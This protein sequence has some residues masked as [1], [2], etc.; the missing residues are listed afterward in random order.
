MQA[1]LPRAPPD[2]GDPATIRFEVVGGLSAVR[3]GERISDSAL[4]SRKARQLLLA[5]LAARGRMVGVD[6]IA[7][8]LWPAGAGGA[9]QNIASLVSRLRRDLGAAV[10]EGGRDGY[11]LGAPPLVVVDLDDA[12]RWAREAERRLEA[13][14]PGLAAAAAGRA[15]DVVGE[16]D[17]GTGSADAEPLMDEIAGVRR[18]A[19]HSAMEARLA[20]GELEGAIAAA[21]A[22]LAE[23]PYDERATRVLMR[24]YARR[25][26]PALA[27]TTYEEMRTRLADDLG[28]DPAPATQELHQAILRGAAGPPSGVVASG[29]VAQQSGG[30]GDTG[31]LVGRADELRSLTDGWEAAAAGRPSLV[32]V[33]GEAG[34]GKSRLCEE[35]LGL[36]GRTGGVVAAIRCYEA[37]RS[38][39]LQ[40]VAD[41]IASVVRTL[42][43]ALVEECLAVGRHALAELVPEVAALTGAPPPRQRS[44]P[45]IEQRRAFD[46][47]SSFLAAVAS[48]QPLLLGFDDLHNAGRSTTEFLHFLGRRATSG[49]L[50]VLAS[51]RVEEPGA[52]LDTL[53]GVGR[54]ID[55]G[56]LSPE[57]VGVLARA[58]GVPDAADDIIRVTGGLALYVVETIRALVSESERLPASLESAVLDRVGR[59]GTAVEEGLRA[60]SVL[61]SAF[62]VATLARLLEQ[63]LATVAATCAEALAARLLVIAG[64]EYEFAHD[65]VREVLYTTMPPPTRLAYHLRAADVLTDRPEAVAGHAAA[66]EDWPRASRAWLLTGEQ[67]LSRGAARDAADLLSRAVE[68]ASHDAALGEVRARALLQR[69]R[70]HA[71]LTAYDA[72]YADAKATVV[73]ARQVGDRRLEALALRE[74]GGDVPTAMGLSVAECVDRLEE[75]LA[76][77]TS[78]GDRELQADVH[79]WLAILASNDLRFARALSSGERAVAAARSSG[80]ETALAKALDGWKTPLA[81]LGEIDQLAQVI[82]EL[83]PLLRRQRDLFR[84]HWVVFESSF[85][86]LAGGEWDTAAG[87]MHEALA[88]Q[89][90]SGYTA[91]AGWHVAHLAWI[92]RIRGRLDRALELGRDALARCDQAPHVWC[93][94][95]AGA[96]LGSTQ[97]EAGDRRGAIETLERARLGAEQDGAEAFLL[98]VVAP[99]ALATGSTQVLDEADA[100]LAGI[101]APAG[102]AFLLGD[103]CYL[104]VARA[105]L[106]KGS[107]DRAREVLA[108][109]LAAAARV[110]WVGG[111]AAASLVDGQAARA[112]GRDDEAAELLHRAHDLARRHDMPTVA[113]EAQRLLA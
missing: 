61:G 13:G 105:W 44:T 39:F 49:R 51:A 92:E 109:L 18:R 74:V 72:A 102:A 31:G 89:R 34:V 54:R 83:E 100:L 78:L 77:A 97:L 23:E 98:R 93:A 90:D 67:A 4:G 62:T 46:A 7:E 55:L 52:A 64:R 17:A 70:A 76:I 85:L 45:E 40:P 12:V 16:T 28:A 75:A 53:T 106:A 95:T 36:A 33:V 29:A 59:A 81:Y 65:L 104:A 8:A 42:S 113:D 79:A 69:A 35:L 87:L 24:S 30:D 66:V 1:D 26:E 58:A 88:V 6:E 96:L 15:L 32:L 37:E 10:V 27:L 56:P 110:P 112:L 86:P 91:Y 73:L 9:R 101:T 84:L 63:P 99:L 20:V 21:R 50:L 48:R 41:A 107:P 108:P 82:A 25:G 80:N 103:W 71:A 38:L 3:A 111:L 94:A 22:A 2:P 60:A 57:A 5:L 14:E 47:A 11:R 43:P 19:R 68:C